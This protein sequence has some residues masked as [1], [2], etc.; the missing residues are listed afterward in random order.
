MGYFCLATKET[1]EDDVKSAIRNLELFLESKCK[2][3]YLLTD[4]AI[5]QIKDA[6]K[7]MEEND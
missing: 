1:I 7:K 2:Y 6:L 3:S 4:F 5:P